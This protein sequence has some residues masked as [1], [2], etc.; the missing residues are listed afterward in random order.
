MDGEVRGRPVAALQG[1]AGGRGRHD[2][3]AGGDILRVGSRPA[4]RAKMARRGEAFVRERR[5]AAAGGFDGRAGRQ[6]ATRPGLHPAPGPAERARDCFGGDAG[7]FPRTRFLGL[8][9]RDERGG[10]EDRSQVLRRRRHQGHARRQIAPAP[11]RGHGSAEVCLESGLRGD[12]GRLADEPSRRSQKRNVQ[13]E[14][15]DGL[16]HPLIEPRLPQLPLVRPRRHQKPHRR[17]R[18][19]R[20]HHLHDRTVLPAPRLP[21]R[22]TTDRGG[23]RVLF[24]GDSSSTLCCC[25]LLPPCS[26]LS[27]LRLRLF[28]S[29]RFGWRQL[30]II[31]FV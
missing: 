16:D 18:P 7:D 21:L 20:L 30:L 23:A 28:S 24:F 8:V 4:A 31:L 15:V 3:G 17:R 6:P 29:C 10:S 19:R 11:R 5:D 14:R 27:L 13:N 22:R 26:L 12:G 1:S 9:A 25:I 2:L